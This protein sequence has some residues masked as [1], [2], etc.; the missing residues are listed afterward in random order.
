MDALKSTYPEF[1]EKAATA[2]NDEIVVPAVKILAGE[3][4]LKLLEAMRLYN[5]D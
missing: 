1:Y 3:R 5:S 2:E 4:C